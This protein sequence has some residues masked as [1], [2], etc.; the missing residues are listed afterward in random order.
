MISIIKR[1]R[2]VASK[3]KLQIWS[4]ASV[5][6][7]RML[8]EIVSEALGRILRLIMQVVTILYTIRMSPK[9]VVATATD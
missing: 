5:L 9:I 6:E 8:P 3:T 2:I 4:N 1:Y 7:V